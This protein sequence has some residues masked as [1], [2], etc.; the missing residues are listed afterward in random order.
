MTTINVQFSDSSE[1]EIIGAFSC[2]QDNA[3]FPNQGSVDLHDTRWVAYYNEQ[4]ALIQARIP[5]PSST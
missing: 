2:A 1:T 3:T 5:P 4:P